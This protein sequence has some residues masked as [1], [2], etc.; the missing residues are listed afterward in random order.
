MV[1]SYLFDVTAQA[2]TDALVDSYYCEL[3]ILLRSLMVYKRFI[4]A[5]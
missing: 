2:I 4:E 3:H 5:A 1:L